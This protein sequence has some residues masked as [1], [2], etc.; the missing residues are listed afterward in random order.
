M[1][2]WRALKALGTAVVRDGVYLLPAS[3]AG[4]N[5]LA[6]QAREVQHSGGSAYLV[7]WDVPDAQENA[8]LITLFD[9]SA[10]YARLHTALEE[11]KGRLSDAGAAP[12]IERALRQCRRDFA[13][14]ASIDHF[15]GAAKGHAEQVLREIEAAVATRVSPHEPQTGTG[16]IARLVRA[17]YQGRLWATRARPWVDR[18]AS[19]WLINHFIDPQARFLWLREPGDCPPQAIGFDF[20]GATFTHVGARVTFE[21][22]LASFGLEDAALSRIAAIVHQLDVGGIAPP[23]AAGVETLLRGVRKRHADDD[24]LLVQAQT[25]FDFLY[26]GLIEE[27]SP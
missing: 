3:E 1:R 5:A 18:L 26:A 22:L 13:A 20:D 10:D 24:A 8:R 12:V 25:I 17:D 7:N 23:E 19:A 14:I 9:R 21:V 6:T 2:I 4:K 16:E 15:P 11:L 27:M